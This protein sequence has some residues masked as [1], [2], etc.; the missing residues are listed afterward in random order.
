MYSVASCDVELNGEEESGAIGRVDAHAA[1]N[2]LL[3]CAATP[4]TGE[5]MHR[6]RTL[7]N[8]EH[9][10]KAVLNL[11]EVHG[12][13]PIVYER[14]SEIEVSAPDE[15][16]HA[17]SQAFAQNARQTLWL[18]QLL[19]KISD[20]FQRQGIEALPYKGP[21]LAQLLYGSVTLRQYSDVDI[22]VRAADVP[23]ARLVL[24]QAGFIPSLHLSAGEEQAYIAGGY[25][26]TFHS[27]QNPNVLELQWRIVP[28]F[29]EVGFDTTHFR[30]RSQNI[31]I[32][33][34]A[35][36]TLGNE[37]LILV[38]CVHAAKHAWSKLSWVR[39]VAELSQAPNLDWEQVVRE[40]RQ[41]G[42]QRIVG[43]TFRLAMEILSMPV[44]L[45]VQPLIDAD[46]AV[47]RI[48]DETCR[49]LELGAEPN[50]ESLA[51]FRFMAELR[52]RRI[53]RLRFWW[54][55]A[56]TPS[57]NEWSLV[58]LPVFLFPLYRAVRMGRLGTRLMRSL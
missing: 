46:S 45:A 38:L 33:G 44:P 36:A 35:I 6:V 26:Y 14:L 48:A 40:A 10:W 16:R 15:I 37:D 8:R 2:F 32:A 52:E 5:C 39:D 12:L 11:A 25:E 31:E 17:A 19:L 47:R 53:D 9:D 55:L 20:L 28:R 58:R 22:L 24:Q 51:Y 30:G 3:A 29:W 23:R 27:A 49:G 21:V 7:A 56:V 42:I 34:N 43:L 54:R 18:T 4:F 13:L 50:V 57:V 1:W 41:L